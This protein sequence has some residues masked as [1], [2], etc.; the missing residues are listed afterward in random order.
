MKIYLVG[1]AVRDK[2]MGLSPKDKDYVV[3]GGN[4]AA[5]VEA[6]YEQVGKDFPVFLHPETKFEYALA[7]IERKVGAGYQGFAVD[8]EGVTL[9]DDLLRRDLSIN[10]MAWC[11]R[12]ST[13]YDPYGGLE[14]LRNKVLRHTSDAFE[15]DPLR[16]LRVARFLARFGEGWTVAPET[17][18]YCTRIV[19][20]GRLN[21]LPFERVWKEL[22]RGLMEPFPQAMIQFIADTGILQH[23]PGLAFLQLRLLAGNALAATTSD[24]LVV[25]FI[26]SFALVGRDFPQALPKEV[27]EAALMAQEAARLGVR[28][29]ES[30]STQGQFELITRLGYG[31][32]S[33]RWS[34]VQ[35][36]LRALEPFDVSLVDKALALFRS[37]DEAAL[38]AQ[39]GTGPEIRNRINAAQLAVVAT[40]SE[41]G[42]PED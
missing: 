31:R 19:K 16:V 5:M 15:E 28:R 6:G 41:T 30:L 25:R 32:A 21:E 4:A 36:A 11:E 8:T 3:V 10:S 7:R 18:T 42:D 35:E 2:L 40:L 33:L 38:A 29:F 34:Q 26:A 20:E 23:T 22:S 37:I 14:D 13:L 17:M 24:D 39:G 27:R 12:T 9:K 1:G